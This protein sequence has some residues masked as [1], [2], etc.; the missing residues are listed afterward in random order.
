MCWPYFPVWKMLR[1]TTSYLQNSIHTDSW[2]LHGKQVSIL[3]P[4][5]TLQK[6]HFGVSGKTQVGDL[7]WVWALLL[8]SE[9][10]ELHAHKSYMES[11][12]CRDQSRAS[13]LIL[14]CSHRETR[15]RPWPL[16]QLIPWGPKEEAESP[17][18]R[19]LFIHS[20]PRVI[21]SFQKYSFFLIFQK[22]IAVCLA[23]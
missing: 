17:Y 13:R 16:P 1:F 20:H 18:E 7:S 22:I 8:D 14:H 4:M 15:V 2:W 21:K 19:S 3:L 23:F 5:Q 10:W 9:P 11:W 12:A 6:P